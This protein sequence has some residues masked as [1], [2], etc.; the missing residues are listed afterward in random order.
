MGTLADP[1]PRADQ[2]LPQPSAGTDGAT[3]A[4]KGRPGLPQDPKFPEERHLTAASL[5]APRRSGEER[6]GSPDLAE[7]GRLPAPQA[8]ARPRTGPKRK[9]NPPAPAEGGTA[10]RPR[11]PRELTTAEPSREAHPLTPWLAPHPGYPLASVAD[12]AQVAQMRAAMGQQP[13]SMPAGRLTNL[14]SDHW[15]LHG[16]SAEGAIW[17]LAETGGAIQEFP[18]VAGSTLQV[19][20]GAT[21]RFLPIPAAP[22]DPT[23]AMTFTLADAWLGGDR[24]TI[25]M[26]LDPAA[27]RVLFK[28]QEGFPRWSPLAWSEATLTLTAN[29]W[30]DTPGSWE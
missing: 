17:I 9:Q 12:Q 7:A 2:P 11:L 28:P 5:E 29:P 27:N 20:P 16:Q 24:L 10:K 6:E 1:N 21:L 25:R 4:P 22:H 3:A 14:G 15:S 8:T 26:D 13:R 18:A 23:P 30:M 19:P